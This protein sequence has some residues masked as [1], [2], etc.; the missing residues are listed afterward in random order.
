MTYSVPDIMTDTGIMM[1]K[2][3][4]SQQS[5][6][7][8]WEMINSDFHTC[9]MCHDRS[10]SRSTEERHFS[11]SFVISSHPSGNVKLIPEGQE[12]VIQNKGKEYTQR[13]AGEH[14]WDL[15]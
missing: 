15:K 12:K 13:P 14:L 10:N 1:E 6:P 8:T 4:P 11:Q 2:T 9:D 7:P 3:Q 5:Y